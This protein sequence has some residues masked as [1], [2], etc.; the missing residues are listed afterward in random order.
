MIKRSA[1]LAA[2][3]LALALSGQ[4]K[5]SFDINFVSRSGNNFTYNIVFNPTST[6][7]EQVDT[8]SFVTLFDFAGA[9]A[10]NVNGNPFT[11]T[12]ENTSPQAVFQ[13]APDNAAITNV[14]FNYNDG[15]ITSPTTFANIVITTS[16]NAATTLNGFYSGQ[17]TDLSVN[18]AGPG[19]NTGRVTVAGP[20]AA[21]PEPASAAML[22]LGLLGVGFAARRRLAK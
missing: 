20:S 6:G 4:A 21:V 16:I 8:G 9:T 2:T 17:D 10:V 3:V 18:P 13:A 7:S 15:T 11:A 22:G 19:G 1:V 5:A 14:R 12:I